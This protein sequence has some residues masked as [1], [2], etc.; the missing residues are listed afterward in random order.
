MA[1]NKANQV[2][3]SPDANSLACSRASGSLANAPYLK[4]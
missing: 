4:R 3:S 2:R 1:Y